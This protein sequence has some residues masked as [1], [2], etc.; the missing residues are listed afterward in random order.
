MGCIDNDSGTN[1]QERYIIKC[2]NDVSIQS[3]IVKDSYKT[4]IE[5]VWDH[6]AAEVNN[7]Y[8]SINHNIFK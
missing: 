6:A 5:T 2:A 4:G 7:F 3:S 8:G 1:T